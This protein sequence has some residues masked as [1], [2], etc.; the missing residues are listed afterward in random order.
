MMTF[1]SWLLVY[2]RYITIH[3][4][5]KPPF[6]TM[7]PTIFHSYV[8]EKPEANPP[9]F[10]HGVCHTCSL[11]DPIGSPCLRPGTVPPR[12]G[13]ELCRP[14][15][16]GKR[17]RRSTGAANQRPETWDLLD[18]DML[19]IWLIYGSYMVDIW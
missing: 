13:P 9:P 5:E 12:I 19:N 8:N 1:H 16:G 15:P 2:Q 3:Q 4:H 6:V 14:R 10:S 17:W 18:N 7:K 11:A